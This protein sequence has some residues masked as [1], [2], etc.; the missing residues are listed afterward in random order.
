[1]SDGRKCM[2]MLSHKFV[3]FNATS[4][5]TIA[6]RKR[7]TKILSLKLLELLFDFDAKRD[8]LPIGFS[9]QWSSEH[10]KSESQNLFAT[11]VL[12][13]AA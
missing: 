4:R 5:M 2:C 6:K 1:M 11:K 10:K 8:H 7:A 13:R 12:L 3:N 9:D